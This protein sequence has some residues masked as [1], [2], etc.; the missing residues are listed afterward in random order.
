LPTL[1]TPTEIIPPGE[2]GG[3]PWW[4]QYGTMG[5][6]NVTSAYDEDAPALYYVALGGDDFVF[7][8]GSDD[9]I[10]GGSGMDSLGG[11]DGDDLLYGQGDDDWISGGAGRDNIFGGS[12]NDWI[13]GGEGADSINGGSGND[14]LFGDYI[15]GSTPEKGWVN[16]DD[17]I[18][19]GA[20]ND[21][22]MGAFGNDTLRGG[23]GEDVLFGGS[24]DDVLF[25]NDGSAD[26]DHD[27]FVFHMGDGTDTVMDY[28]VGVDTVLV[29]GGMTSRDI[30]GV[31]S[32]S[33]TVGGG[34]SES[35]LIVEFASGDVLQFVGIY[36]IADISF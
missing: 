20:G 12:G 24:G 11:N 4:A 31:S 26:G 19:G 35:G 28:E 32:G 17:L 2:G 6:D 33:F 14:T 22:I 9:T 5:Q 36:D 16:Y 13:F 1:L 29:G 23:T 7:G 34:R 18:H 30:T 25:G 15:V 27:Q 10:Y 21:Q 8:N 3:H